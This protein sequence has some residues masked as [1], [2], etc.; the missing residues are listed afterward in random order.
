M[1]VQT[2]I[3]SLQFSWVHSFRPQAFHTCTLCKTV[4]YTQLHNTPNRRTVLEYAR[5]YARNRRAHPPGRT[6][7]LVVRA[8]AKVVD[9]ITTNLAVRMCV[10]C[11]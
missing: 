4:T 3:Q 8:S 9:F 5:N 1:N 7:G 10:P 6:P 2:Q 11:S